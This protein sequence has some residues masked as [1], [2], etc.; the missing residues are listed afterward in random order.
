MFDHDNG[1][2]FEERNNEVPNDPFAD[3]DV[4]ATSVDKQESAPKGSFKSLV[5]KGESEFLPVLDP[6]ILTPMI[7][8]L[9]GRGRGDV[10]GKKVGWWQD[11][12]M[13]EKHSYMLANPT[14]MASKKFDQMD[15]FRGTFEFDQGETFIM[16]D[17]GGLQVSKYGNAQLVM[18]PERHSYKENRINPYRTVEWQAKNGDVGAIIEVGAFMTEEEKLSMSY[19]EWREDIFE[20]A[21]TE[22]AASA[23][24]AQNAADDVD[25][26][27][28]LLGV[29]H[30]K[31]KPDANDPFES[32]EAY[33]DGVTQH[34]DF[35]GWAIGSTAG[36]IGMLAL[37]FLVANELTDPELLHAFGKA[38]ADTAVL[39]EYIAQETNT[40][41]TADST[42]HA[43]GSRYRQFRAPHIGTD[44]TITT[45]EGG[46]EG[47]EELNLG[48]LPCRCQVCRHVQREEG[49]GF[50]QDGESARRSMCLQ[51]HNLNAVLE[52]RQA[53]LGLMHSYTIDELFE[54]LHL[55]GAGHDQYIEGNDAKFWEAL[56]NIMPEKRVI[57]LYYALKFSRVAIHDGLETAVEQYE[58][59]DGLGG[60]V[61]LAVKPRDEKTALSG[62]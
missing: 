18:E 44:L 25:E 33:V 9:E 52:Q 37:G 21:I 7:Q 32:Y 8:E 47:E 55:G 48:K 57:E 28:E 5:R 22:T 43:T 34:G 23:A 14:M 46:V 24:Q 1:D 40:F 59:S 41:V 26:E 39:Q 36:N 42:V 54:T 4:D 2:P 16:M 50:I 15:N 6:V 56:T 17:S 60:K 38:T 10:G 19:D 29:L 58:F 31:P 3:I 51:L 30:G 12:A 13:M 61:E 35:Y 11:D 20:N 62:W 53:I 49:I 27:F 45:Q